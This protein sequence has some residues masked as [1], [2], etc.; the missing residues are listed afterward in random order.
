MNMPVGKYWMEYPFKIIGSGVGNFGKIK[1][2]SQ[3]IFII[4]KIL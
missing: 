1:N 2:F 3:M 4:L